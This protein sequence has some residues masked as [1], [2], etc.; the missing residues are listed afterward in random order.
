V[1]IDVLLFYTNAVCRTMEQRWAMLL[2]RW[3]VCHTARRIV[4]H[5]NAHLFSL[6]FE[7]FAGLSGADNLFMYDFTLAC[8][9]RALQLADDQ[10]SADVW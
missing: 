2:L 9:E 5:S 6:G 8:F 10:T 4:S 3:P 7:T 1:F